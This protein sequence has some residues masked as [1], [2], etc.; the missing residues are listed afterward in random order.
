[1]N[2]TDLPF[3]TRRPKK[4]CMA[5]D[6]TLPSALYLPKGRSLPAGE[7]IK[8]YTGKNFGYVIYD[9]RIIAKY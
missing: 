4:L 9:H 3:P 8:L 5:K 1:M 7:V 2:I 6:Y